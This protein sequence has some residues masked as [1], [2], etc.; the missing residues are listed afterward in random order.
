V[1]VLLST[2]GSSGHITP[3]APFGHACVRAGHELLVAAQPG[4]RALAE[5]AG[6]R[7]C[8]VAEKW[9]GSVAG[10]A[11]SSRGLCGLRRISAANLG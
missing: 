2:R 5:L 7:Q 4:H 6:S 3:L 10:S 11:W 9:F 1:R 8:P